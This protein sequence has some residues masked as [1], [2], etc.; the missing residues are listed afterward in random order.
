MLFIILFGGRRQTTRLLDPEGHANGWVLAVAALLLCAPQAFPRLCKG[1]H[2]WE[3]TMEEK[4]SYTMLGS[5]PVI[6][7]LFYFVTNAG[8]RGV[9]AG[10]MSF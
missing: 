6:G 3:W 7:W 9:T 4:M 1:M 5:H 10:G 8:I 2:L